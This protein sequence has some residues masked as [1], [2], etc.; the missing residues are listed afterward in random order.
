MQNPFKWIIEGQENLEARAVVLAVAGNEGNPLLGGVGGWS[1]PEVRA[2][3]RT[4]A[5]YYAVQQPPVNEPIILLNG[6]GPLRV[7]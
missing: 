7:R 3:N 4:T 1:V 2:W 5:F 6:K